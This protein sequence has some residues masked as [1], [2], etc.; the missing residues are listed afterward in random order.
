[1]GPRRHCLPGSWGRR[2]LLLPLQLP[3]STEFP[4][5]RAPHLAPQSIGAG[6]GAASPHDAVARAAFDATMKD[7]NFKSFAARAG[8]E[9]SP[10][11]GR[12]IDE[13]VSKIEATDDVRMA[14]I[15]EALSQ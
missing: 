1:M 13:I 14:K 11:S 2:R 7:E 6:A 3:I 15:R 4:D 12:T 9:L 10:V 8:L 5:L